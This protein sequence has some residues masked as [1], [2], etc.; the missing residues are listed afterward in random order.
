MSSN[1]SCCARRRW[2]CDGGGDEDEKKGRNRDEDE[3]EEKNQLKKQGFNYWI[4]PN[5]FR[6]SKLLCDCMRTSF[7]QEICFDLV[8]VAK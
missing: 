3:D 5:F 6:T 2:W 4:V 7:S 1:S 8:A